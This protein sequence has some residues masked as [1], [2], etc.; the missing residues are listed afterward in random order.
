MICGGQLALIRESARSLFTSVSQCK[1]AIHGIRG[2]AV[3]EK[4][5]LRLTYTRLIPQPQPKAP[6]SIHILINNHG[7]A[8]CAWIIGTAGDFRWFR[9]ETSQRD[10]EIVGDRDENTR[11]EF[12]FAGKKCPVP[13]WIVPYSLGLIS[14]KH[15]D[16]L[17]NYCIQP[18]ALC[19]KILPYY[20]RFKMYLVTSYALPYKV[21]YFSRT[22][23]YLH[24]VCV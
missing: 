3:L 23:W 9:Y 17:L 7:V 22:C 24:I 19:V 14:E 6:L 18:V 21:I 20:P 13:R 16:V 4:P 2:T 12:M 11:L 10:I 5:V 1:R 15:R 8:L